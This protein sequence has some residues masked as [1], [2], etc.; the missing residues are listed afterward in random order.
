[1]PAQRK[2]E[3][4]FALKPVKRKEK[5]PAGAGS[6]AP[7]K[8]GIGA[9]LYL[10]GLSNERP[11]FERNPNDMDSHVKDNENHFFSL[12][13]ARTSHKSRGSHQITQGVRTVSVHGEVHS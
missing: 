5:T 11:D 1:M 8:A 6:V 10:A 7:R 12:L 9:T 2:Q 4:H 3:T 13:L